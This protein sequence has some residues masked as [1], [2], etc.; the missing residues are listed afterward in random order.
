MAKRTPRGALSNPEGRF[1]PLC[2]RALVDL[3]RVEEESH[4]EE[5]RELIQTH[6][7]YTKSARASQLLERWEEVLP[8]FVQVFPRDYKR[9]LAGIEYGDSE[10]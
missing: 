5:L 6:L 1:E 2:N 3:D 4:A 7:A 10:Y 8:Q 9:A